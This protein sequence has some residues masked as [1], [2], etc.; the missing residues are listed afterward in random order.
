LAQEA[1]DWPRAEAAFRELI[2]GTDGPHFASVDGGLR[3][4]KAR[5]NLALVYLDSGRSADA[6]AEWRAALALDPAFVPALAGLGEAALRTGDLA[7]LEAAAATLGQ[8][9]APQAAMLRARY[10]LKVKRYRDARAVLE[11]AFATTPNDLGLLVL[12][13]H[14]WLQDGSDPTAAERALLAVLALAPGNPEVTHNLATLRR[15]TGNQ[16]SSG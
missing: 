7:A 5:H 1:K 4:V 3:G 12:L 6:A 2:A 15:T 11:A 16:P 14:A 8:F 10:L 9:D 13:S